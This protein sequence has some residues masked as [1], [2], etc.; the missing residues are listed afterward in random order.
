[1]AP[2][3]VSFGAVYGLFQTPDFALISAVGP[4]SGLVSGQFSLRQKILLLLWIIS[5]V[6]Q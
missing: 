3:T 1:M 6:L 2:Y 4:E 5:P